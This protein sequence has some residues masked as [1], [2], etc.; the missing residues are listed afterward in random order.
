MNEVYLNIIKKINKTA[1]KICNVTI[2]WKA[3]E[4]MVKAKQLTKSS[5]KVSLEHLHSCIY[6]RKKEISQLW[7]AVMKRPR[8]IL[9]EKFFSYVSLK[10]CKEDKTESA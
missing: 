9:K 7:Q 6:E 10:S 4:I 2:S 3:V 5:L 8:N 1:A